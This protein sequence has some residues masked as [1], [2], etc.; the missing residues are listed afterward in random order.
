MCPVKEE[1][2]RDSFI[3]PT[4]PVQ[5]NK[6]NVVVRAKV[7]NNMKENVFDKQE[8]RRLI[9]RPRSKSIG[10]KFDYLI[11]QGKRLNDL[12]DFFLCLFPKI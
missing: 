9:Q 1:R 8:D 12:E 7:A 10:S 2:I 5:V 6:E 11:E 3:N 4:P